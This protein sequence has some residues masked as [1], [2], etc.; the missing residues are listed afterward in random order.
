MKV[1]DTNPKDAV[2]IKKV[3]MSCVP[4]QVMMEVATAMYEGARKYGRSNYR[5]MGVRAS[6]Y[7]DA[8]MRHIVAWWE[9]QDIDED[10][11]LSHI[12][13]A[14]AGLMV[15]RDGMLND[16][17]IDDRSPKILNQ[18]FIDEYNAKIEEIIEKYPKA[19]KP[20]I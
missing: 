15:L 12:T 19:K 3:P 18:Y 17:W 2:G 20:Y 7:Y 16:K 9:G 5:V 1:K 11:G 14:I 13:K 6:V 4:A 10:S 8:C